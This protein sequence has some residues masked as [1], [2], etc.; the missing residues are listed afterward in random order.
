[1][2]SEVVRVVRIPAPNRS[3]IVA[4]IVGCSNFKNTQNSRIAVEYCRCNVKQH[5]MII[6]GGKFLL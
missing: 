2:V 1:M 6:I 3:I 5:L 4:S